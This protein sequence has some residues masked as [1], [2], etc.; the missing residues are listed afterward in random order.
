MLPKSLFAFILTV[1]LGLA[2]AGPAPLYGAQ[3]DLA[4]FQEAL[5]PYGQWLNH[6]QHGLVWRP[7]GVPRGWRPYTNGRWVPTQEGYVFETEE[8]W[9]WATYHYGNWLPTQ[10][11]GW[12][13]VP[14]RTW[15]PH[16]VNWRTSDENVGWAP[17]P[18][19][20]YGGSESY[21]GRY[22]DSYGASPGLNSYGIPPSSWVFTRASDFLLGWDQPYASRYSYA[23]AG[24]LL[25]PQYTP[26]VYE[27]TVFVN[28]Y[29]TPSY[30]PRAC[31][32]WG[33]PVTYI[34]KVTNIRNID[35]ERRG[36]ERRLH[37]LRNVMPPER[38]VQRHPAWREVLPAAEE[39]RQKHIRSTAHAGRLNRPDAVPA[40]R[41][42]TQSPGPAVAGAA[43]TGVGRPMPPV[44]APAPQRPGLDPDR[45]GQGRPS[46]DLGRHT[47]PVERA[48]PSPRL[49]TG[50]SPD[51]QTPA[52]PPAP[53][54][55][56]AADRDSPRSLPPGSPPPQK[57]PHPSNRHPGSPPS[58]RENRL[59]QA[60]P[61]GP[62]TQPRP[63]EE[64]LRQRRQRLEMERR[65]R[66]QQQQPSP[67]AP[68][69]EPGYLEHQRRQAE[70]SRQQQLQ[71]D[72][73]QRRQA[74]M[75]QQQQEMQRQHQRQLEMQRQQQFLQEQQRQQA[76]Q[77]QMQMEN[78]RRQAEMQQRQQAEMMRARQMQQQ[79]QVVRQAPPPPAAPAPPPQKKRKDNQ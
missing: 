70:I 68:R 24:L 38:V 78:Q 27:R 51:R 14:G 2:L 66:V 62:A 17:V 71:R 10:E 28:N 29:V 59:G 25:G 15:Y 3:E 46:Q 35:L 76:R 52:Q 36:R 41:S 9:G 48:T 39:T 8:P 11:Y 31:Y 12:V 58:P 1:A 54:A 47:P 57:L 67:Q 19:P 69:P 43:A 42:L 56:A 20:D 77:Q 55:Q 37:H 74:E 63:L 7:T 26:V 34:T 4:L 6:G 32:N 23:N 60:P 79:Q 45:R 73:D 18:P 21:A 49:M 61:P 16:T 40:P 65:Q 50:P 72:N 75:Q 13:W 22:A 5:A 33:P 44:T 64:E 53:S 30:A